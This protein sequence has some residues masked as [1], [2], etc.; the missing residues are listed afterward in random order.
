[1]DGPGYLDSWPR[2]IAYDGGFRLL[3]TPLGF[4]QSRGA[5]L[6]F[7]AGLD[8]PLPSRGS[9]VLI[10]PLVAAAIDAENRGFDALHLGYNR[11]IR[12]G[13]M[14]IRMLPSGMGPGAS[15][16]QIDFENRSI[17]YTEGIRLSS[18]LASDSVEIPNCDVLLIGGA[19][20]E[21]K[22]PS[23]RTVAAKLKTWIG[24]VANRGRLPVLCVDSKSA[25]VDAASVLR[26]SDV[27]VR[28][29]RGLF[30]M[31]KRIESAGY[32]TARILRLEQSLP[33]TGVVMHHS[34]L[35][36][37]SSFRHARVSVAYLGRGR[38]KPGFADA[39]FRFGETEDRPGW[40]AYA[41]K[42][43]AKEVALGPGYGANMQKLLV[44]AGL[45]VYRWR[46][47]TQMAL[48]L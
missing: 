42:T 32:A 37:T 5:S 26:D 11:K 47:P 7:V 9:R 14:D 29:Q 24:D 22:P 31:F 19:P 46:P 16:I 48:K 28:L 3:S 4:E 2:G 25:A 1:M 34:D 30:E 41:R 17:V 12:L 40:V 27:E 23:P 15:Q 20:A 44:K 21:P 8:G 39:S 35:W 10:S 38:E 36:P 18:A 43:G 45:K 13:R 33:E 6:R